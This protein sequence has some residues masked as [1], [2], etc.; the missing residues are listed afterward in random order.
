MSGRAGGF[1]RGGRAFGTKIKLRENLLAASSDKYNLL[2]SM[3]VTVN[4]F[5]VKDKLEKVT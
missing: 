4:A 1:L 2:S 3:L 5:E